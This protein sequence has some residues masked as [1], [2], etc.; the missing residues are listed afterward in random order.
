MD[1]SPQLFEPLIGEEFRVAAAGVEFGLR[2]A[3]LRRL[4]GG[5]PRTEPFALL[6]TGAGG[7]PQLSQGTYRVVHPKAEFE[8]FLVPVG[9]GEYEAVFN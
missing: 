2:L 6:F 4:P 1:A 9:P 7:T 5:G 8:V 3:D